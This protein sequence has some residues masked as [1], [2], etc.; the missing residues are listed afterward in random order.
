LVLLLHRWCFR[1]CSRL[2][3]LL[4]RRHPDANFAGSSGWWRCCWLH[5]LRCLVL[6]LL[7]IIRGFRLLKPSGR[8][9]KC[10]HDV[11]FQCSRSWHLW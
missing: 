9:T 2:W 10:C 7:L 5:W 6:L 3:P 4:L 1:L 8:S 11:N